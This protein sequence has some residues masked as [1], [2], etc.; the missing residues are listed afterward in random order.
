MNIALQQVVLQSYLVS[1]DDTER[2]IAKL[3]MKGKW[4][5]GYGS[6]LWRPD[7]DFEISRVAFCR[8]WVRHFWQGSPDHR[9]TPSAPGRVVTLTSESNAVC[10]GMAF[11][12]TE[13]KLDSVVGLLNLR[14]KNGYT[15]SEVEL[16]FMD[17][18]RVHALTY[19]AY[20]NNVSYLGPASMTEMALQIGNAVGPSGTN[21]EYLFS[22]AF[23]LD[24]LGIRDSEVSCLA[25]CLLRRKS[26]KD[27]VI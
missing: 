8:G 24:N 22:L 25:E 20:K 1:F 13:Q 6:L 23:H 4:I 9:G 16:E 3:H 18:D 7:F 5:F 12:V 21:E 17:G 14:E 10:G 26:E 19:I 11:Y 15:L 2:C 27:E